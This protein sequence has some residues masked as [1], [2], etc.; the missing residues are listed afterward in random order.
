MR[1]DAVLIRP[2]RR[3]NGLTVRE[4]TLLEYICGHDRSW[5]PDVAIPPGDDLALVRIGDADVLMGTDQ[6]ADGIH[7]DLTDCPLALVARKALTRN[8]SDVA[9]MAARPVCAVAATMLPR[10]FEQA[11]AEELVDH[12][13]RV[14]GVFHCPVVGG[15]VAIWDG[16]LQLSVTIIA[17]PDG[18]TPVRRVGAQADDVICV[19]GRL[20]GSLETVDGAAHHLTFEPRIALARCL[21]GDA[22]M[23]PGCMI[24]LS[25]GL[26]IDLERL[27]TASGLG[28]EVAVERLPIAEAAHIAEKR[29]G[30]PAWEHAVGDGEDYEL[31]FTLSPQQAEQLL[32]F[33][34]D[35]VAVTDVGRMRGGAS[36]ISVGFHLDDGSVRG[37]DDLGWEHRGR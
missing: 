24:D 37:R 9:A 2:R 1:R 13:H 25:D 33:V 4:S 26:A 31:L 29:D 34:H 12:L 17:E 16:P 19:S 7:F 10:T 18:I 3:Y 36:G 22:A 30:R 32:P 15:D 27:C 21:A 11:K 23:R 8:L 20:G 5:P 6:V 35:G 28:A 14:A